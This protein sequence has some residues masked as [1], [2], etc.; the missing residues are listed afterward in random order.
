MLSVCGEC[1][2]VWRVCECAVSVWLACEYCIMSVWRVCGE[3]V[4]CL[5]VV[6]VVSLCEDCVCVC[7]YGE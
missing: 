5:Y 6:C 3:C 7:V 1:A 2:I 4:M